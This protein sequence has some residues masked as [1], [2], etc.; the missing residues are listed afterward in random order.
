MKKTALAAALLALMATACGTASKEKGDS[1]KAEVAAQVTDNG[2]YQL[3]DGWMMS[4]NG[5]PMVV[6]FSAEWCPPC[7]KLK[8]TFESLKEEYKGKIDFVSVDVDSLPALAAKYD[9]SSIPSLIYIA[10]DGAVK[11]TTVGYQEASEIKANIA[12]YL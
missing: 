1:A 11:H 9:V 4:A 6:D 12:T 2:E 8:P 3:T 10:P 5:L 7:R